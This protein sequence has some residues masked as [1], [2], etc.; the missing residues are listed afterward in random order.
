MCPCYITTVVPKY[1]WRF[2]MIE[3]DPLDQPISQGVW[4]G[5]RKWE[6]DRDIEDTHSRTASF[7]AINEGE[8]SEKWAQEYYKLLSPMKLVPAGR[9]ASNAGTGLT[10]T[11][12]IN[13]FVSGFRG[14]NQDSIGSIYEE[15]ARQAKILKSEG[16]YGCNFD[17]LRPRGAYVKGI[18]VQSPG[19]V[20]IMKLWD[21]SS[22]IITA[23]SGK[24]NDGKGKNKIRKGAMMGTLSCWHPS[25]EEFVTVKTNPAGGLTR[26][27]LS[28]LVTDNFMD[29][30]KRH[31]PW[32]LK[33][34]EVEHEKYDEEWDGDIFSWEQKGYP[35]RIWK[36][37]DDASEL[38]DL[39]MRSNY[40]RAEPGVLFIDRVNKMNNLRYT[41]KI[42]TTNPCGEQPLPTGGSCVLSSINLVNYVNESA[43]DYDYDALRQDIPVMLRFLDSVIDMTTYPLPEQEEEAKAK[44]RIGIGYLGYGSSLYLLKLR[45]GSPK[46]LRVTKKLASFVTNR[47]Y[48]ASADL[49]KEKGTFPLY[50]KKEYM[51]SEF[52]NSALDDIVLS[53]IKRYGIRN[54]HV[55]T[56]APTGNSS[57]LAGNVSS[58]IE[59]VVNFSYLRTVNEGT[60]PS[61]LELPKKIDWD[62]HTYEVENGWEWV[63]EEDQYVLTKTCP[64]MSYDGIKLKDTVFKI[65]K[66]RGLCR[67]EEVY[68]YAYLKMGD[69]FDEKAPYAITLY[70]LSI[71]DHIKTLAV[72]AKY[73][74]S[75]V[76]KTVNVP[77][78][79]SFEDFKK[80]YIKAYNTGVIK[81][82]TTFRMGTMASVISHK[83]SKRQIP[84][85]IPER[86]KSL[87]C[88]V[89][90]IKVSKE[91]WKVFVGLKEGVPF[92]VF[93]GK[94]EMVDLPK[95]IKEGSLLRVKSGVYQFEHDG[96]ILIKD[97]VKVF[98]NSQH[99]AMTRLISIPLR[100]GIPIDFVIEQINKAS[101]S[102]V[103]FSKCVMR[104]LK[105]YLP[106]GIITGKCP[107]CN[108]DLTLLEGC[109]KCLSCGFAKCS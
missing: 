59:P 53:K 90:N 85:D 91:N 12:L 84:W 39:I 100:F 29:A 37:Y 28:V 94:V 104:A 103:D 56:N 74:D 42:Y 35:V 18:G 41:E 68:D 2:K 6:T 52:L 8:N 61:E 48:E 46:A 47:L 86:P 69:D 9:I 92:E 55:T 70:D 44:R 19:T 16:G 79:C 51:K 66:E 65:Y 25:V 63:M 40:E 60:I 105:K 88:H 54:S 87:P 80:V 11:C 23:G 89:Y 22:A 30:V 26:F 57:V 43:T 38:W 31:K 64:V 107:E 101:G 34:P 21:A 96:E 78:D 58:G 33:F 82:L 81:G 106:D 5:T 71:D 72:F 99:D 3:I 76:S 98:Q 102:V 109:A 97:L 14:A 20:E 95:S 27:N 45:Y 32:V 10:G 1:M 4:F 15:V 7:M 75:A 108:S 17:V 24:S 67:E 49:A 62:T 50:D 83:G 93:A 36:K 13:C 73:V 77:N